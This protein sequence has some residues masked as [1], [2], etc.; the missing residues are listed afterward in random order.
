M[1]RTTEKVMT[2][3]NKIKNTRKVIKRILATIEIN[4]SCTE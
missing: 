1:I 4:W 2:M 3:E